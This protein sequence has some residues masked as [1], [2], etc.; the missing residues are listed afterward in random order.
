MAAAKKAKA[1]KKVKK[2]TWIPVGELPKV[3]AFRSTTTRT[4]IDSLHGYI[5]ELAPKVTSIQ[6]V[7]VSAATLK[8]LENK[9]ATH[10][11][12]DTGMS[13]EKIKLAVA[14]TM[15]QYSPCELSDAEDFILYVRSK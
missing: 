10:A 1:K 12:K 7:G 8:H 3:A 15:L 4:P 2:E 6:D 11:I 5:M 14:Y 13:S 9:L